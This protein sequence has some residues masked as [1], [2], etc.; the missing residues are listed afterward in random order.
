MYTRTWGQRRHGAH[1]RYLPMYMYTLTTHVNNEDGILLSTASNSCS[2][3]TT[4]PVHFSSSKGLHCYKLK[5]IHVLHVSMGVME[6][7]VCMYRR[8]R[9]LVQTWHSALLPNCLM[10]AHLHHMSSD[11]YNRTVALSQ[12]LWEVIFSGTSHVVWWKVTVTL[13]K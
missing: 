8:H 9:T 11:A 5:Y 3:S 12:D 4:E 1:F 2:H 6:G 13:Q 10:D 7:C